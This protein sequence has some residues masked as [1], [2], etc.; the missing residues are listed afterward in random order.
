MSRHVADSAA[1]FQEGGIQMPIR[2]LT[3]E[4]N[5]CRPGESHLQIHQVSER[6][7]AAS[8][9]LCD[10][11]YPTRYGEI[12]VS[13]DIQ[14]RLLAGIETESDSYGCKTQQTST[15]SNNPIL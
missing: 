12:V 15:H 14:F 4:G 5:N 13:H 2:V 7:E 6:H 3:D 9:E 11:T 8:V 10:G 1:Q